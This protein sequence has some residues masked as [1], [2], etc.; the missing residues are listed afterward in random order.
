MQ[1]QHQ[2]YLVRHD[3]GLQLNKLTAPQPQGPMAQDHL[4]TT[5]TQDADWILSLVPKMNKHEVPSYYSSHANNTTKGLRS[6]SIIFGKNPTCQPTT[7][8][9]EFIAKQVLCRPDSYLKQEPNVRTLWPD[10]KTMV[11]Q[12]KLKAP[13]AA[14]KQLSRCV[15]PNQLKTR[16]SESKLRFRGRCW[17]NSSKFSSVMEMTKV[18]LSSQRSTPAHKSSALKIEEA[19]SENLCSNL[20]PLE[21]HL[22]SQHGQCVMAA[23]LPLRV[24]AAW[25]V[26]AP[27]SAASLFDGFCTLLSLT[28]S[29]IMHDATSCSREDSLSERV[30]PCDTMLCLFFSA[31]GF[32]GANP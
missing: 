10:L 21:G 12:T 2:M 22:S 4:M 14:T 3:P 24:F 23:L 18:H 26:E 1:P 15:N 5:E 16:R 27:F 32:S 25:R 31:C 19:G 11:S 7:N 8:L 20:P 13:S 29:V 6:G 9:S 17:P 30:G 28:R